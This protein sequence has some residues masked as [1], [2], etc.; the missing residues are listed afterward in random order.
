[1]KEMFALAM[2]KILAGFSQKAENYLCLKTS[3]SLSAG[4]LASYQ[5]MIFLLFWKLSQMYA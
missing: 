2:L 1:M 4:I 3:K 5:D